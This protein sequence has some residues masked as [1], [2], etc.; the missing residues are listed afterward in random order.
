M[1][2][3]Q[4]R[5]VNH[6]SVDLEIGIVTETTL[7]DSQHMENLVQQTPLGAKRNAVLLAMAQAI[8]SS[9]T[10]AAISL[11]ALAGAYLLPQKAELA[12]LPVAGYAIGVALF[13]LPVA[14]LCQKFGRKIGFIIGAL[15]GIAGGSIAAI[16]ISGMSFSLFCLGLFLIGGAGAFVHQYRFAAADH[17]SDIFKSKAISW[18]MTGGIFGAVIGPQTIL[19]T[20]DALL[21]VPYAGAFIATSGLLVVGIFVLAGLIAIQ[22]KPKNTPIASGSQRPLTEIISQPKFVVALICAVASAALMTFMMTGAPLAMKQ[23]GHSVDH[24]VLGIQWHVL[25][26]YG[27]SLFTGLLIVRFGKTAVIATGLGLLILCAIV[28]L[29]GLTL[30]NF[31]ASLILLGIGWNFG[32]I[33]STALLGES[34]SPPEKNKVQGVHDFI[35]FSLV[36]IAS[37][38]SGYTL[39]QFGWNGIAIVLIPIAIMALIAVVGLSISEN[40]KIKVSEGL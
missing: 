22:S 20:K 5:K 6:P 32:F 31:W 16:A 24:A 15:I 2:R 4:T 21:P 33:G 28:A 25:A 23:H 9:T 35:L 34:Y 14:L 29:A 18:V 11:G 37:L 40:R 3:R 26:M 10:S 12:T 38:L 27:P 17:G 7:P 1:Q 13:A 8:N 30:W 19:L 39:H 36:A